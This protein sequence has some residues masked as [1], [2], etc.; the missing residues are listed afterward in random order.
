MSKK[1]LTVD[2]SKV[3]RNQLTRILKA[4]GYE[5]HQAEDGSEALEI[6]EGQSFDLIM[7]DVNMPTPGLVT[8]EKLRMI[9]HH[10]KTPVCFLTTEGSKDRR[11]HAK[12]LGAIAWLIKPFNKETLVPT[13]EA[14]FARAAAAS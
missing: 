10:Q 8:L 12:S 9:Q 2:D 7:L 11:D 13:V 6:C 3:I 5:V 14:I 1:I 4:A